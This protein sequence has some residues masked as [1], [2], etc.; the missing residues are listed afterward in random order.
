M[1]IELISPVNRLEHQE[2]CIQPKVLNFPLLASL[3]TAPN[4]EFTAIQEMTNK[5]KTKRP[6]D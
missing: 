3:P 4:L 2:L 6:I 1:L 5:S